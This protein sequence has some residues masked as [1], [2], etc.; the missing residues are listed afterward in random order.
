MA[1]YKSNC[2]HCATNDVA[3]AILTSYRI[4]AGETIALGVCGSCHKPLTIHAH[5]LETGLEEHRGDITDRFYIEEV[6]PSAEELAAPRHTPPA[7]A[8]RF[9]EG[10]DGF[11]RQRWN[12]A[13]AMYR[14]ALD[15]ATKGLSGVPKGLTFYKRL[16]WLHDHHVITS[17]MKDWA[18]HVRVEGNDALHDPEDFTEADAAPLRLFTETFLRYIYELPGEVAAFRGATPPEVIVPTN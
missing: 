16:I 10:E 9:I 11:R 5:G 18:D 4:A 17:Q 15:I 12:S 13:V 3:F 2:P 6:W 8:N 14:S 1:V 7:I